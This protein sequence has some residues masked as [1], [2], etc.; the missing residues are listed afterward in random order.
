MKDLMRVEILNSK[1]PENKLKR[2]HMLENDI[3]KSEIKD[4]IT[5]GSVNFFHITGISTSFLNSNASTWSE[6]SDYLI[7]LNIVKSFVVCNDV[8][9]RGVSLAQEFNNILT[10]DE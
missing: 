5:R 9:E 8:A 3:L 1:K 10:Q 2:V 6:N 4:F 7:G